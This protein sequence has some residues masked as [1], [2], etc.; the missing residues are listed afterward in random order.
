MRQY[1]YLIVG[2]GMTADAAV[3]GIREIDPNGSIG[4]IGYE[5]D[6]PYARPPLSKG[7]WKGRPFAKVWRGTD[8]LNVDF[9][10]GREA[11]ELHPETKRVRD[12]QGDEY[13]YD[14]L[15]LATGGSPIR[16]PFGQG[17][18]IYFR[19]LQDFE[20][21]RALAERGE[22]FLVI[23]AGF[24]GTEIA[25]ALSMQGKHVSMVFLENSIGENVYPPD[26]SQFINNFYRKKGVD[27]VPGDAVSAVEETGS[28]LTVRT[29]GGRAFEVDGVVAGLGLRP[30]VALAQS[31]GLR[32]ENGV[33]VDDH[34]RTSAPDI[35]AAGDAAMFPHYALGKSIRVEH[36]DNA[37]MMGKQAG[38]NMAG[39]DEAYTHTPIFYSDMFELGYEAVG[40]LS[41]KMETVSDWQEQ[42]QK[43]VIYYLDAGR[44]RG[45]LLWNVWEKTKD[46]A[47]LML[48]PGPFKA[49]D[50][51]GRISG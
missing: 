16:L 35:F 42:F 14:K 33:V 26:L 29:R 51:K 28:R 36:E 7:M 43:G 21:L 2:S 40:E 3:R 13:A 24:I 11:I 9:H 15:L 4:M 50:L 8:Q 6:M 37:L 38:R 1:K 19:T 41:S 18:I 32:V 30:N 49:E 34:L 22:K 39:A 47:A 44:V 25:A 31:A 23:G 5:T 10:L 20:H 45:V 46:A 27:L 48:E 17:H 12:D